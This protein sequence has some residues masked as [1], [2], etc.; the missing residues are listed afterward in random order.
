[1]KPYQSRKNALTPRMVEIILQATSDGLMS[2]HCDQIVE[3]IWA[4]VLVLPAQRECVRDNLCRTVRALESSENEFYDINGPRYAF[5]TVTDDLFGLE[6]DRN[7]HEFDQLEIER[8]IPGRG[9]RTKSQGIACAVSNDPVYALW[10]KT[11]GKNGSAKLKV[12][13]NRVVQAAEIGVL[14]PSIARVISSE[15]SG[16]NLLPSP[17]AGLLL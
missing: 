13:E 2:V 6:K 5:F 16:K 17:P 7:R 1:M 4:D 9:A 14:T 8:C 12:A 3:E 11:H 15:I 10:V